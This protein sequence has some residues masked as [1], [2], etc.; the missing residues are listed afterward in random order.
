MYKEDDG[1]KARGGIIKRE[2]TRKILELNSPCYLQQRVRKRP[3]EQRRQDPSHRY[4]HRRGSL[5]ASGSRWEGFRR[6]RFPFAK[7]A[8]GRSPSL[9]ILLRNNLPT[10]Q[11]VKHDTTNFKTRPSAQNTI[12]TR[13]SSS[14]GVDST[15]FNGE[16]GR[17]SCRERV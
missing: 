3:G 1:K 15:G 14:H 7:R 16:I 17:A 9:G 12:Y 8:G 10:Y 6:V 13:Q 5:G 4:I 2:G 11:T